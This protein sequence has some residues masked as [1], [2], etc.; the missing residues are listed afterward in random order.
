MFTQIALPFPTARQLFRVVP[1]IFLLFI[2]SCG[3]DEQGV[4]S[5]DDGGQFI[6]LELAF[7]ELDTTV[8]V[9]LSRLNSFEFAPDGTI[10][11]DDVLLSRYVSVD[12]DDLIVHVLSDRGSSEPNGRVAVQYNDQLDVKQ[13]D[14]LLQIILQA[15]GGGAIFKRERTSDTPPAETKSM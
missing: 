15:T 9:R 11:G 3:Q 10:G 12:G 1:V 14:G 2:T 7:P 4:A 6:T 5:T 13:D 8:T